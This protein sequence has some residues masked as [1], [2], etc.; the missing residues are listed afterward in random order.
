MPTE[1]PTL[2]KKKSNKPNR[3]VVD[4]LDFFPSPLP[5]SCYKSLS[6]LISIA[7]KSHDLISLHLFFCFPPIDT[8]NKVIF[9]KHD[10]ILFHPLCGLPL[11]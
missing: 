3:E 10:V 11:L 9:Q 2:L 8:A 4:P 1:T 6:V 7:A 5:A